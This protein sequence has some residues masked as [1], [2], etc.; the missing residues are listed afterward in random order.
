MKPELI[1]H[2]KRGTYSTIA[3]EVRRN[4]HTFEHLRRITVSQNVPDWWR[5]PLVTDPTP[6][7]LK[8]IQLYDTNCYREVWYKTATNGNRAKVFIR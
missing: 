1:E 4:L 2:I 3:D 6:H 5:C 7:G 8:T